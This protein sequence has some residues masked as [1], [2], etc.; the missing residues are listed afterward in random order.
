MP[1]K[2][3]NEENTPTTKKE[4]ISTIIT[5]KIICHLQVIQKMMITNIFKGYLEHNSINSGS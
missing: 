4:L 2:K 5:T 1:R 3:Q